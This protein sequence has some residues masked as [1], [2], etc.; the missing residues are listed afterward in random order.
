MSEA[1]WWYAEGGKKKGPL[2]VADVRAK[3]ITDEILP[4]TP[5]WRKGMSGWA[6][7][8]DVEEF[9]E[10]IDDAPPPLSEDIDGP[11]DLADEPVTA[12]I[13]P[14]P[15][16]VPRPKITE[17][18]LKIW[19]QKI[20]AHL[21]FIASHIDL[22]EGFAIFKTYT[23]SKEEL[24]RLPEFET[25]AS[26]CGQ[27]DDLVQGWLSRGNFDAERF[28]SY[29]D[30][31]LKIEARIGTIKAGIMR[32]KPT[33]WEGAI[34]FFNEVLSFVNNNLH[35]LPETILVRIGR[36]LTATQGVTRKMIA[37]DH[38]KL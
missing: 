13:P 27:I 25:V 32:R 4:Q 3:L 34:Q 24:L 9:R 37:I 6:K 38:N 5:I 22:T 21:D 20:F 23:F 17:D 15:N 14:N 1:E 12:T 8:A 31:R 33:F 16:S 11:P 2:S 29:H 26:T 28:R 35:L 18:N 30:E 10:V 36:A 7:L 19:F